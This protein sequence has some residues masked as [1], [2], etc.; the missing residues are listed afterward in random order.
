MSSKHWA[1]RH[2]NRIGDAGNHGQ[3]RI[4]MDFLM[5]HAGVAVANFVT[6]LTENK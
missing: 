5:E 3:R 1:K 2:G 6:S 4:G